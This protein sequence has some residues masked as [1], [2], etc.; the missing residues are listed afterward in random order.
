MC[1][2]HTGIA[3][4]QS[5]KFF[6]MPIFQNVNKG[7]SKRCAQSYLT[8]LTVTLNFLFTSTVVHKNLTMHDYA[9]DKNK[10]HDKRSHRIH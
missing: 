10:I 6:V 9:P 2:L 8:D 1:K 4:R 3:H 7:A 5:G